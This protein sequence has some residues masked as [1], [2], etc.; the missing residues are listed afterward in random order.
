MPVLHVMTAYEITDMSFDFTDM[1]LWHRK[2]AVKEA[3]DDR[4]PGE[5]AWNFSRLM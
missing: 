3:G 4:V 5:V 1:G 2:I